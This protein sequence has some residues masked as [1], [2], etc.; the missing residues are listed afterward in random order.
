MRWNII[1]KKKGGGNYIPSYTSKK[2]ENFGCNWDPFV[3]EI[4]TKDLIFFFIHLRVFSF[5]KKPE[6]AYSKTGFSVYYKNIFEY[7]KLSWLFIFVGITSYR[8]W[9][10][11]RFCCLRVI[12]EKTNLLIVPTQYVH[13]VILTF[14]R[15]PSQRYGG[16]I[17]VETTL[18]PNIYNI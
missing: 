15:R 11:I 10:F 8:I 14:I 2:P 3:S 9:L 18:C 16:W 4:A 17:G 12:H 13:N 6:W 5:Y 1:L 7:L